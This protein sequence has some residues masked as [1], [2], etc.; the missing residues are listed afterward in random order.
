MAQ[1][2][3][4]AQRSGLRTQYAALCYRFD[5]GQLQILMITS[6]DTGRWVIP[7]GWPM[8]E[9]DPPRAAAREAWEEAGVEGKVGTQVLGLYSYTKRMHKGD[10]LPCVVA[11]FPLK[12]KALR[13]KFPERHER[14]RKWFTPKKA[15][16][17]VHE[18]ELA[19]LLLHFDPAKLAR[20]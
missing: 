20:D 13:D 17:K 2:W 7:K 16:S 3:E 9:M 11:V 4:A 14:T 18:P 8:G 15:A 5:K 10:D 6:R 19:E 12:V 1:N